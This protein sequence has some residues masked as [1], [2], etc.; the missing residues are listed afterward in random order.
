MGSGSIGLHWKGKLQSD[1]F[2]ISRNGLDLGGAV[3][4]G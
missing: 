2:I 4:L 3:P 1:L